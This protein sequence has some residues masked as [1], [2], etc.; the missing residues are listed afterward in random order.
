MSLPDIYFSNFKTLIKRYG[1]I[2]KQIGTEIKDFI[3]KTTTNLSFQ[4]T[5]N[6]I[7]YWGKEVPIK[8]YGYYADY[9]W[10]VFCWLFGKMG[11]M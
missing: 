1:K 10:V 2:N 9:D 11:C 8:F 4:S 7:K 3:Y 6:Q 5:E